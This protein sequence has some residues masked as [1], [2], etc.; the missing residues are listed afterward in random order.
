[1]PIVPMTVN[2]SLITT[3]MPGWKGISSLTL[4]KGYSRNPV[5]KTNQVVELCTSV[6][7]NYT[8]VIPNMPKGYFLLELD[9]AAKLNQAFSSSTA[10]IV[11]N[12]IL[13]ARIT[14]TDYNIHHLIV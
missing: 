1:M 13:V 12:D 11:F 10:D 5:W 2:Y 14:P 8:Q 4:A 9:W 7:E 3:N 6:N